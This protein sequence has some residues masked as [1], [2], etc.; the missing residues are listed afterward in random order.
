MSDIIL[1]IYYND[2]TVECR[3]VWRCQYNE[4]KNKFCYW[5]AKNQ[6]TAHEIQNA[7]VYVH[8]GN[9]ATASATYKV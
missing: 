3:S 8:F 9:M 1:Q 7:T 4:D 5:D 2:G 6:P